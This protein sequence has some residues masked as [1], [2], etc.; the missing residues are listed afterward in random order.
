MHRARQRIHSSLPE[1]HGINV[2]AAVLGMV[3]D[4]NLHSPS[5]R[6]VSTVYTVKKH[7]HADGAEQNVAITIFQS[8]R[9]PDLHAPA[10][11]RNKKSGNVAS[12]SSSGV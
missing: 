6:R 9:I 12:S 8:D 11:H 4:L 2:C 5:T 3:F 1:T 7:R 10:E